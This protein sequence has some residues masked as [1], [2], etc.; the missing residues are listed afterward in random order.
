[1]TRSQKIDETVRTIEN[2]G[3]L[4]VNGHLFGVDGNVIR[5]YEVATQQLVAYSSMLG[6]YEQ[7]IAEFVSDYGVA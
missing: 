4:E 3:S 6:D 2:F 1:M 7:S 5:V